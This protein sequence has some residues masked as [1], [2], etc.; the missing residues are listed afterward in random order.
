MEVRKVLVNQV[1]PEAIPSHWP[2][3]LQIESEFP[4]M[5]VSLLSILVKKIYGIPELSHIGHAF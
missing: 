1:A 2:L 3:A 5:H 4:A